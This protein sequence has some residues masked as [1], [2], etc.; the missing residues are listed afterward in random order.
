[1]TFIMV[2]SVNSVWKGGMVTF[3]NCMLLEI[4]LVGILLEPVRCKKQQK[5][6]N[7]EAGLGDRGTLE[8]LN[9]TKLILND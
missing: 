1:M 2:R 3:W 8:A 6:P 7:Q 5:N 9:Y 4:V